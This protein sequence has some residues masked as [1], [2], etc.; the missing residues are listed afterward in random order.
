MY[1]KVVINLYIFRQG[2]EKILAES[3]KVK[4]GI[5]SKSIEREDDEVDNDLKSLQKKL[6]N[7]YGIIGFFILWESAARLNWIDVQFVP[8]F[9]TV[10][11]E[12]FKMILT[13][14]LFIHIAT[15]LQRVFLG[16]SLAIIIAVPLGFVL[17]GW[18]PSAVKFLNPLFV[19]LSQINAFTLFP[20]FI[21]LFGIGEPA[22]ISI[23]FWSVIWPV[24]FT[25]MAGVQQVDP[26]LIKAARAMGASGAEIFLKVILPG[27]ATRIFTGIKTGATMAFM[28]LIGAEM[29]GAEAGLGWI[30]FN[31]QKNYAI[32]RLYVGIVAIAILG[33]VIAYLLEE[34]ERNVITWKEDSNNIKI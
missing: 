26:L 8:A 13:G 1:F 9:S 31:S 4:K 25:T 21:I 5:G 18:I 19:N 29:I 14:E 7:V 16:F 27:A 28:M 6:V 10:L 2:E 30:I 3:L 17:G 24:L 34:V 15:S 23:I 33:L 12:G 11:Q 32:P 20:L 22:K